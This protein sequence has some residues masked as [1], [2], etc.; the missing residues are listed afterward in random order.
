MQVLYHFKGAFVAA[1]L[2]LICGGAICAQSLDQDTVKVE[3]LDQMVV[4]AKGK[5]SS[6]KQSVPIQT[7]DKKSFE[8]L[9]MQDLYEAVR[10]FSGVSIKDYGGIGGVKTVSV[11]NMGSQHTAVCYDGITLSNAQSG[12]IDIGR[13]SLDNVE[14]ISLSIG[15]SDDIFQ[16][17]RLFASAGALNIRT[18]KPEFDDRSSHVTA[19]VRLASFG[20]YNPYLLYQQRLS[21]KWSFAINGDWLISDG[22]YPF[23]IKNGDNYE[24]HIRKNS[25]VNTVRGEFNL[26]GDLGK[27]G[28]LTLKGNYLYSH[29]GLPGSVVLYNQDAS[30]W[31]WDRNGFGSAHY[32]N[33]LSEQW[34]IM[35]NLKYTYSWNRYL[36]LSDRLSSGK[37]E[38][39][40]TQNEYYASV[41]GEF[42]PV[43]GVRF[44][45]VEDYFVNTLDATLADFVYPTRHTSLTA[46]AGQYNG[47]RLT[48]T[49]S[50]LGTFITEQV[51]VGEPADDK[52][53]LSPSVSVSFKLFE[54]ANFRLRA[55]YKDAYRAPTFNDLYYSRVGNRNLLPEKASQ[56]NLGLTWSGVLWPDIVEY[57]SFSVDGYSNLIKDKI[58]AIPTMFVW[59]MLNIGKVGMSGVDVNGVAQISLPEM[60]SL[61]L[62][63][64]YSFQHAVDISD[65]E[66]KTYM[67]QIPYTPRHSGSVTL[68]FKSRWINVS[69]ICTAV[70][71]RYSFPQNTRSNLIDGYMDHTVSLSRTFTLGRHKLSVMGEVLN[72]GNVNYEVVQYYPMPGRS[73]RLTVK[74]NF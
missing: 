52:M 8:R 49:A 44:T 1:F 59:R 41:A 63:A 7:M 72:I 13:F 15:Q 66:S 62:N 56:F 25:Q 73:Y 29:R 45:L 3:N 20:T 51:E 16:T 28:S 37:E 12:Q 22:E 69:Y 70:G 64:N 58:V 60:M 57:A 48:L 11:R 5:P 74:Y 10:T 27:G 40:Y 21:K 50:L 6:T 55:S 23:T 53:R 24:S 67:H 14:Q 46:L 9:G 26:Y 17:A 19:S 38:T 68:S 47:S 34:A 2:L 31:L 30:E 32:H 36:A 42:A 39:F 35:A 65:P 18:T 61:S 54:R 71:E 43:K 4:T 33:K